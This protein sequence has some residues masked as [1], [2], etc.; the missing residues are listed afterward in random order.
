MV[1]RGLKY[2]LLLWLSFLLL[3]L[4]V[5][6]EAQELLLRLSVVPSPPAVWPAFCQYL[7][8]RNVVSLLIKALPRSS[9]KPAESTYLDLLHMPGFAWYLG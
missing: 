8:L 4:A 2:L 7:Y 5:A 1:V 9:I 3:H 6:C